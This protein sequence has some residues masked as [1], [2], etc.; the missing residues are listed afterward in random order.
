MKIG[1]IIKQMRKEKGLTQRELSHRAKIAQ[2]SLC[3]IENHGRSP[4]PLPLK[5]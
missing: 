1:A 3:L 2:G 5:E 4:Y